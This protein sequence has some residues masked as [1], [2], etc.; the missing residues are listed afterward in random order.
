[1]ALLEQRM[2][3]VETEITLY[4]APLHQPGV[5]AAL[6]IYH[7]REMQTETTAALAAAV[8]INLLPAPARHIL[9]LLAELVILLMFLHRRAAMAALEKVLL[10]TLAAV[11]VV[12]LLLLVEMEPVRLAVTVAQARRHL[13][14]VAL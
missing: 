11:V 14:L 10:L 4:L 2:A 3:M 12:V 13:F 8:H 9:I 7:C 6:L 5:G 1:V